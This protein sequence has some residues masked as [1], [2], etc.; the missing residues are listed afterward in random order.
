MPRPKQWADLLPGLAAIS[1]LVVGVVGV[2]T[3]AQ[4]GKLRG[5]T[6]RLY[7]AVSSARGVT[8]GSE[9]WL[10]G[11]QIGTVADVVFGPPTRDTSARVLLVL[12]VLARDREVVRRDAAVRIRAGGNLVGAPVVALGTGS[13]SAPPVRPGDTL[14]S[15]GPT[16]V[17]RARADLAAAAAQVPAVIANLRLLSAQ[18]NS[19]RGTL[20]ALGAT[21]AA[22]AA[23][24]ATS[25]ASAGMELASR[26]MHGPG[27]LGRFFNG[28]GLSTLAAT[29]RAQA[30]SIRQLL[31]SS[32]T[33]LGRFRRDS[34][35]LRT[36]TALQVDVA[37]LAREAALPTGTVGRARG[38]R[39]LRNAIDQ[40]R[41]ELEALAADVK[42][43]PL[44]YI[45]F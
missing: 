21:T 45:S 22:T 3:V 5:E 41:A 34:T 36:I 38:D 25:T 1:A 20:G 39:A 6:D 9:V 16:Y 18:L 43:N 31:A 30:D 2:L 19:A 35:L 23:L 24:E 44:R 10:A 28:G 37:D 26:A 8:A 15:R 32:N 13:S 40:T 14:V 4:V 42:R 11:R 33:S 17:E 29:A 12:D 27:S 7:A